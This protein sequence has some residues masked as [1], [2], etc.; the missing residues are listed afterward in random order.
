[1]IKKFFEISL[2]LMKTVQ[3]FDC[4]F[5]EIYLLVLVHLELLLRCLIKN[6]MISDVFLL[7]MFE[8]LTDDDLTYLQIDSIQENF[9][10]QRK[11]R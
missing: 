1:M 5:Y 6:L 9:I 4:L 7:H 2:K 10:Q 8:N 11:S 3:L